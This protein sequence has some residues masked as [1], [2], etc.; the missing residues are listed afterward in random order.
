VS[1]VISLGV[2]GDGRLRP[3]S[4]VLLGG[5]LMRHALLVSML[6]SRIRSR[7]NRPKL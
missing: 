2:L 4:L 5:V 3:V 6:T 7:L 1:C